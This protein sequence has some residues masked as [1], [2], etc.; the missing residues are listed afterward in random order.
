MTEDALKAEVLKQCKALGLRTAHFRP[1]KTKD[2]WRT[3][4][5]GDGKG[6]PDLII[7]GRRLI[8][9]ELK[10]DARY[11][12]PN[13]RMWITALAEAGVDVDVWR[14][15]DLVSGRIGRELRA[16]KHG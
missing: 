4:V 16:V 8:V 6:W 1:A 9:R 2:G 11:P 10:Q 12:D 14:P 5:E 3:P 13:Q 7:V 15:R